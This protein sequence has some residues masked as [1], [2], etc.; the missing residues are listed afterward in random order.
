MQKKIANFLFSTR[1]TAVLFIVFA[2]AMAT[3]TLLDRNMDTS[4]TPYTRNLIYNAWWFEAIMVFFVI[5]FVGNIFRFRLFRKEKW[6]TLTLHLAFIFILLGAFVTRYIGYEGVMS[7]R[8]GATESTMLSYKT[9]IKGRILGDYKVKGQLQQYNIEEEVDFSPRLTNRFQE[10]YTYGE[11][12]VRIKLREFVP[13]A[14][15]DII[16]NDTGEA[17]LKI[18]EAGNGQPHNHFIKDGEEQNIHNILITLNK[19]IDGA[20]NI[21][22]NEDGL[23]INSPFEGDY[24]TMATQAQG[25]LI[26]DSL[27]PLA[28]RSRYIIQNM[29]MV[30]PKP[31]VKGD[32]GIVKK[33]EILKGDEDGLVIDVTANGETKTLNLI[34]GPGSYNGFEEVEVG[35]LEVALTYGAKIIQLPFQIKLNDFIAERYA[36][37]ENSYSSFESRVTVMDR[38]T[39]PFDTRIYMN[40]VLDHHGYRFFQFKFDPD[41]KGTILSVNHDMWGTYITYFGYLLLY[42]GLM[43]IMFAKH[44]RFDDLRKQLTK[45]KTKKAKL[46]STILLLISFGSFA[47]QSQPSALNHTSELTQAQIDSILE[48]NITPKEHADKFGEVVVQDI[49]GR[50]MPMNT[51]ASE[52][53]RKLTK[54][55]TYG[56]YDANQVLLSMQSSPQLWANLP[57]IYLALKKGDSIRNIIGVDKSEKY[58][59][60]VDFFT[61]RG[62]YKI[63]PYLEDAYSATI[64]SG[65]QKEFKE[66]HNRVNLILSLIDGEPLRVFPIPDD[67]NN[68]WISSYDFRKDNY[69]ASIKDSLYGNF[70][71]NGL[72][73]YFQVLNLAKKNGDFS[74]AESLLDGIRQTQE[75]YGANVVLSKK[76]IQTEITYNKYDIFKKLFSWY[77][78]ASTVLFVLIIIQIFKYRSKHIVSA[79]KILVGVIVLLFLFHTAGLIVRWYISGHAP[80]S[81]AYESMIYVAWSLMLFGLLLA[82]NRNRDKVVEGKDTRSKITF[83]IPFYGLFKQKSSDLTVAAAAFV[84]SMIL[85]I[86]HWNWMD[87]AIANLQPVLQG[88]WLMIH[89]SVIVG[90]YGPLALGM[91]LGV[92]ALL[93]MILTNSSNKERMLLNIK[94]ITIINELALTVGLV[95]LT[96]G[97]FLGGMW[98]NESWGRYWGWDPK[99]TWALISIMIYAFVI[100]MRL[101]PGLRGRWFYSLM[102]ILAFGSILMTYFGVNFYLSGLHSYATGD[103]ILSFQFIAITLG[104]IAILAFLAYRKHLLYY[105]K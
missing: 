47:Q 103:Q 1:L 30:F 53:L 93:L 4:P 2:A 27:Q 61:D 67:E 11:I 79:I 68:K 84:T 16:P 105:K 18:V 41:E 32:F 78:Y 101:I 50:M 37:T 76:K 49:S 9:Y 13:G 48:V 87:P 72:N 46:L 59:R 57:L 75:K 97:N 39:D 91:I 52:V 81:D 19:H 10:D 92:V 24:L 86:A 66:T 44:T 31:V 12:P 63:A 73:A 42:F 45:L 100:H 65:I 54:R 23:F 83:I 21:I 90:S 89:V 96:I 55:E 40:N 98:A 74:S 60:F 20:I 43:A 70:I 7:I 29:Q 95:M 58:I 15:K 71:N 26:K 69:R 36:G 51:F 85:M 88:Y 5:N 64:P 35:G 77:M 8:E 17:Y 104:I 6:A 28:L 62:E 38:S 102:S 22:N 94:E 3:G 25:K 56:D 34:G 80:W 99:E 82:Y 14:E 33:P